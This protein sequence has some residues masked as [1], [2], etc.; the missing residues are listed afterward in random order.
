MGAVMGNSMLIACHSTLA[1]V[2][3]GFVGVLDFSSD[4]I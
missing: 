3:L 1:A 2:V 4:I